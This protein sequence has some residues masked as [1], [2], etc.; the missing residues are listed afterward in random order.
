MFWRVP[1]LTSPCGLA[2]F[3][4]IGKFSANAP[5]DV[6]REFSSKPAL[7][8]PEQSSFYRI[9]GESLPFQEIGIGSLRS[10]ILDVFDSCSLK[11]HTPDAVPAPPSVNHSWSD[12][13]R[14]DSIGSRAVMHVRSTA[15]SCHSLVPQH[16]PN[17]HAWLLPLHLE[18][19]Q[20]CI[21]L[22]RVPNM[23]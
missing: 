1:H 5:F 3:P 7:H 14:P 15:L 22:R 20:A 18:R 21:C 2:V 23:R 19:L 12:A 9:G 17:V 11:L 6:W 8:L 4:K 13:P 10:I 16:G